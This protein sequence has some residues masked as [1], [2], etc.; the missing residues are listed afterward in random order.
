MQGDTH[1]NTQTQHKIISTRTD[2][3]GGHINVYAHALTHTF[4]QPVS[5]LKGVLTKDPL[6]AHTYSISHNRDR[7]H[8]TEKHT[9]TRQHPYVAHGMKTIC[10]FVQN[11]EVLS[12]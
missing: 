6:D 9:F 2:T 10:D 12:S 8:F 5:G 11:V 1:T 3:F 4:A 7:L